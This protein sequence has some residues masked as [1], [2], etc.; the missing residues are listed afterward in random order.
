M[1]IGVRVLI[2]STVVILSAFGVGITAFAADE[3]ILDTTY[4]SGNAVELCESHTYGDYLYYTDDEYHWIQCLN[5]DYKLI[6]EKH[7]YEPVIYTTKDGESFEVRK[8]TK[9]G[10]DNESDI[11]SILGTYTYTGKEIKP[12]TAK[13]EAY[14]D[15]DNWSPGFTFEISYENNTN[16]GTGY[17]V[18]NTY[19]YGEK[20]GVD[21]FSFTIKGM[22][23]N[24]VLSDYSVISG[25]TPQFTLKVDELTLTE[26][27][28]YETEIVSNTS[29]SITV[30]FIG[31]GNYDGSFMKKFYYSKKD[32][33]KADII[34][35]YDSTSYNGKIQKPGVTVNYEG[36]T[37]IY[38]T[39]YTLAYSRNKD[40]GEAIVKVIGKGSYKGTLISNFTIKELDLSQCTISISNTSYKYNGKE[41]RPNITVKTPDGTR[42]TSSNYSIEYTNNIEVGTA[43]VKITGKTNLTGN[44]KIDYQIY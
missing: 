1:R 22:I 4:I 14:M 31:K 23:T 29:S 16:I 5:C 9:C 7:V 10:H 27:I 32:I 41:R 26:G 19:Y 17:A 40:A 44:Y 3:E 18:V 42:L 8:C 2:A 43:T 37:L 6:Y 30:K 28:D 36:K 39:D 20:T 25:E 34:P 24:S 15:L 38:G 35:E 21:K 13:I 33:T 12:D 11:N